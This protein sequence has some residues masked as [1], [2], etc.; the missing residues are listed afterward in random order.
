MKK[1]I[2]GM[3]LL[4]LLSSACKKEDNKPVPVPPPEPT[5]FFAKG[6]DVSWITEMESAGKKLYNSAGAE[7]ECMALMK[8]LGMNSIRLRVW[9]NPSPAWNNTADVLA[10]ALRAKAAGLKIMIDFHYSDSWADPGKQT[11]PTAWASL[12]VTELLEAIKQH[13]TSVLTQLKNNGITP[14]WVQV[15][16][17]TNDGMLWPEGKASVNMGNYAQMINAGYDAVKAVFATAKV[18]VHVSNGWDNDLFKWNIGGLVSN[19]ARFD[20]IGMSVYPA[21]GNWPA[22]NN[23]CLVNMNDMV[24]RY[25][26][27]V[28]VVEVGMPWD[29]ASASKAFVTDI[30]TKVKLVN[31]SKGIGV[32]YWEPQSYGGWKGYTL[33]AFD[34]SGRPTIA[35]DAF[36]N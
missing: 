17:E 32:F 21:A 33:G 35:I 2:T 26:K 15:G 14:E 19:G 20:V 34:N 1:L 18:I 9:V 28:M 36:A 7:T 31:A 10:K 23:Q 5:S 6:A 4:A 3:A 13:T 11:K 29:N 12:S 24:S 25:N 27:E 30:I 8:A 22:I 16:N